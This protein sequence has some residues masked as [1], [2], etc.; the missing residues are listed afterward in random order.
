MDSI[1]WLTS[2]HVSGKKRTYFHTDIWD[3]LVW[4]RDGQSAIHDYIW[5]TQEKLDVDKVMEKKPKTSDID[6]KK[7]AMIIGGAILVFIIASGM[8]K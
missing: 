6:F 4:A 2:V 8:M 1:P 5:A 3:D 7:L